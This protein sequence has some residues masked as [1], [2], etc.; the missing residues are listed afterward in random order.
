MEMK[1]NSQRMEKVY[2]KCRFHNGIDI[3]TENTHG[4]LSIGWNTNCVISLRS[5][6]TSHIDVVTEDKEENVN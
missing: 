4:G 5:F 3:T 6:S 2:R 1:L